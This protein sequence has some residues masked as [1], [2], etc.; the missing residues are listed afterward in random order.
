[1]PRYRLN[2]AEGLAYLSE[3][4]GL[5]ALEALYR[6]SAR[7]PDEPGKA[8][9]LHWILED[10]LTWPFADSEPVRQRDSPS[11]SG[12]VPLQ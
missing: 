11:F 4:E 2:Y 12:F 5:A 3:S 9:P 1:M 10:V 6:E 7:H 8:V